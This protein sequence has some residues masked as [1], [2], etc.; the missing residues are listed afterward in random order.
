MVR[1]GAEADSTEVLSCDGQ[2]PTDAAGDEA[3]L[4]ADRRWCRAGYEITWRNQD[5][6]LVLKF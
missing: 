1:G 3:K 6:R 4:A 2:R 5:R